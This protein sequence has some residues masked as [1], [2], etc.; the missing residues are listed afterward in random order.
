[1]STPWQ[2]YKFGGSSLG[3]PG[4][5]PLVLDL[6]TAAAKEPSRLAVVVSALGD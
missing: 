4:R 1:M 2:V 5:L 3:T 6:I